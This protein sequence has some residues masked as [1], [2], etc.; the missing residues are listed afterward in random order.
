MFSGLLPSGYFVGALAGLAGDPANS[1]GD[2]DPT[3]G[4][5]YALIMPRPFS[6]LATVPEKNFMR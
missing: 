6:S 4:S 3:K 1:L 5:R 2:K